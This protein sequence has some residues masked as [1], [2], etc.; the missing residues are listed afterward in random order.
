MMPL[1]SDRLAAWW[2]TFAVQG[3][4][5]Y[6]TLVGSGVAYAMLP[7]LRRI[8]AGDPVRL[9]LA[10]E[11][12]MQPFNTHPYLSAMAVA[13][14]ARLEQDETDPDTIE[15][16]R[17]ALRGP[18]GTVGDRAVWAEWRPLCLLLAMCAL[19]LGASAG[20]SVAL[21]L[22]VYNV[23][24][25]AIRSWAFLRGW[26][27]GLGV[28]R[29]LKGSWVERVATRLGGLNLL[30]VGLVTV[31][32]GHRLVDGGPAFLPEPVLLAAGAILVL[33]AF[34]FPRRG[35][36]IAAVFLAGAAV[37]WLLGSLLA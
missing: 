37:T 15:R 34:R 19:G 23:G 22:V 20:V 26:D 32:L 17:V 2:R 6:R 35:A 8:Y 24:H 27:T 25:I 29:Y 7:L 9:R 31:L 36:R 11:R 28:G 14:L 33:L 10:L 4:W 30:L 5:N 21:F 18:L 1:P 3:S 13:S 16:F 12:H